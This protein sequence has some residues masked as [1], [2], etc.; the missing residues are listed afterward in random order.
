MEKII[1]KIEKKYLNLL[2][3]VVF[4]VGIFLRAYD[5]S[6]SL[7][8]K[9]DQAR[10]ALIMQQYSNVA[11]PSSML[12]GAQI[13]GTEARL[14]PMHYYFQ[15]ISAR[16][17]GFKPEAFAY[18]DLAWG[19]LTI[20]AMYFLFKMFFSKNISVWLTAL[21]SSSLMLIT[22]SRFD[23][24]PNGLPFF[25]ALFSLLFLRAMESQGKKRLWLLI[26]ASLSLG[27][28][29]QLHLMALLALGSGLVIFL[30]IKKP[31]SLKELAL[32]FF[33]FSMVQYPLILNEIRTDGG[34]AGLFLNAVLK[35]EKQQ[36]GHNLLEKTFKA[37]QWNS[38]VM[39]L[40]ATG[41][42]NV[43][44]VSTSGSKIKCDKECKG[45]LPVISIALSLFLSLL[46]L[47]LKRL[48]NKHEDNNDFFIFVWLASFLLVSILLAYEL[49]YRFFLGII[50]VLYLLL[51]FGVQY[52]LGKINNVNLR[53]IIILVGLLLVFLNFKYS[54]TYLKE[55]SHSR[56]SA[57]ESSRDLRFGTAPKVTLGQLNDISLEAK[58]RFDASM[59]VIVS[60]E[61]LYVKAAY[62]TIWKQGFNG[63]YVH[64]KLDNLPKGYNNLVLSYN[65]QSP[66]YIN[67]KYGGN[68]QFEPFGTLSA[69]FNTDDIQTKP[70][71]LPDNCITY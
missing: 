69:S 17:F 18:P 62:Y 8:F 36:D 60:G 71:S 32:A 28:I 15:F 46:F 52:V 23:W 11:W 57:Q 63:C 51:G 7:V 25:T 27:I 13:G 54:W 61:S 24:N 14:G 59:P 49:E 33:F 68:L 48:K 21:A 37:L 3:V 70:D 39:W 47:L 22:F 12:L 31:F 56:F 19:M 9:S 50:P 66:G 45:K 16:I 26:G 5:F 43:E 41:N 53:R 65:K 42:Q 38:N 1:D 10:D 55:L 20:A 34:N 44:M 4:I 58:K 6:G 29:A 40:L 35:K 64:G 30:A 2:L 67:E